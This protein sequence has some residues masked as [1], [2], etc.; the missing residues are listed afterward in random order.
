MINWLKKAKSKVTGHQSG[1][2]K[3]CKPDKH[4]APTTVT[5]CQESDCKKQICDNCQIE[6]PNQKYY[7]MNCFTSKP[8]L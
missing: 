3:R 2:L 1:A 5:A 8:A 6:A 7:C 4:V